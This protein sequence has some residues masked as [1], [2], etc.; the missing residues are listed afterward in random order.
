MKRLKLSAALVTA[1][2][3][4]GLGATQAA[5]NHSINVSA[6]VQGNCKFDTG[7]TNLAFSLDPSLTTVVTQNA[8]INY[9]CTKGTTPAFTYG[10]TPGVGSLTAGTTSDTIPYTYTT[11]AS[12][13]VGSGMGSGA[14]NQKTLTVGVSIDQTNA[15]NVDAG[16]SHTYTGIITVSV[17][18]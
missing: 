8:N 15:Q 17:T 11:P 5:D 1:A 4:M 9:R 16:P 10:A 3:T 6:Q 18:P 14:G 2:F 12:G 7:A 13:A